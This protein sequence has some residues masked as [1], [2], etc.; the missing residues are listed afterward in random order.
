MHFDNTPLGSHNK[1]GG[2]LMMKK[3]KFIAVV[4][5]VLMLLTTL[6]P[7]TA[8]AADTDPYCRIS[9]DAALGCNTVKYFGYVGGKAKYDAS[10]LVKFY[11]GQLLLGT[12][13]TL[14]TS[15]HKNGTNPAWTPDGS[16][17]IWQETDDSC[18]A[19]SYSTGVNQKIATN[20]ASAGLNAEHMAETISFANGTSSKIE[21][22]I[23][24][25][26]PTATPT[27]TATPKPTLK[28]TATPTAS[29]SATPAV[30]PKPTATAT[31][32]ATVTPN[33]TATPVANKVKEWT[34]SADREHF[35]FNSHEVIVDG[36]DVYFNDFKISEL[37]DSGVRYIGVDVQ[38]RVYLYEDSSASL[39]RFSPENV[40]VPE[41]IKFGERCTLKSVTTDEASRYLI[42]IVTSI[43]KFTPAQLVAD[44]P[45]SPSKNFAINKADYCSYYL[46]GG[47]NYRFSWKDGKL[48]MGTQLIRD[49]ITRKTGFFAVKD[50]SIYCFEGSILYGA[51]L[52]NPTKWSI[53][54]QNVA[55]INYSK[56]NGMLSSV[57][58][59][60]TKND[61]VSN[62]SKKATWFLSKVPVHTISINKSGTKVYLDGTCIATQTKKQVKKFGKFTKVGFTERGNLVYENKKYSYQASVDSP[63]SV[64]KST[65]KISRGNLGFASIK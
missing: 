33:P 1:K 45:W 25:A 34:D 47:A 19:R 55:G 3:T 13:N 53:V 27:P 65:K 50:E 63:K 24:G 10:R 54:K 64:K 38:N 60:S 43:G 26:K 21:D 58:K 5:A 51:T 23:K 8:N 57:T 48:Y 14:V 36:S 29:P 35:E 44:K 22:L 4:M 2:F 37:C 9:F 15:K 61:Y 6:A 39:Y 42:E 49:G 31:P 62:S 52:D 16:Y 41:K 12:S 17:L 11:N 28:P 40:F 7:V 18:W 30:T 46:V 56:E 59:L 32:V 20:V